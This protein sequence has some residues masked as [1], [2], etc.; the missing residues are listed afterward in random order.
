[1]GS[2]FEAIRIALDMLRL[3]KLRAFLT[4]L[5]VIIGVM[6]VTMIVMVKNGFQHY[7]T[8]AIESMGVR[9][10]MI[11]Y[12][13]GRA[14]RGQSLGRISGLKNEDVDYLRNQVS[15][16][17]IFSPIIMLPQQKIVYGERNI[18]NPRIMATDQDQFKLSKVTLV[19]GRPFSKADLDTKANVC[20]IGEEVRDRLFPNES[21]IGKL[22]TFPGIT[23][24][25][26]GVMQ[27]V[28]ML[29]QT[30]GRDVWVPITTAQSKWIGGDNVS[31][32]TALPDANV[33]VNTAMDDVWRAL[34]LKSGNRAV[35]RV[36]SRESIIK[37]LTG[38]VGVAGMV[39]AAIAALSLLVGGIGIMNIMLVS[40]TER[41]R[42][43]GLRKAVG[44]KRAVVLSQ[45]LVESAVL[46]LVGGLI[47]MSIAYG[48]G[49]F[50]SFMT[51]A[52]GWPNKEGLLTPF[53]IY[54][55]LLASVFSAVI[56]VIFGLYP[57]ARAAQL[58][59]I[60]ALRSE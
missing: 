30:N 23:L 40:V 16:V 12:D 14:M 52:S 48:L 60:E 2:F 49:S 37:V 53:P 59:P 34:M 9:T 25:V 55:A 51:K 47:G 36:D 58:S 33:D 46:S 7:M 26:I 32:I 35:Y 28:E 54:A 1:M 21:P 11:A 41:T 15:T 44:A 50:I 57:A 8:A 10:L 6:S 29:G 4:M 19:D 43:I 18:D 39:L 56:G 38:I 31:F 20:L 42:E 3:Y 5:G 17:E 22:V 27:T 24:Q 45:F 13:P